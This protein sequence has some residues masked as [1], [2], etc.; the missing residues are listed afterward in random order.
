MK[1]HLLFLFL[2]FSSLTTLAQNL[3]FKFGGGLASHYGDFRPVGAFR[4]GVGYEIEFDQHFTF[5]PG[6]TVYGKGWKE[7]DVE[8][9]AYDDDGNQLYDEDTGLPLTGLMNRSGTQNYIQLPLIF[10]YYLRTGESRYIVFS[11]GPYA[12]VGVSGHVTTKGDTKRPGAERY[13]YEKKTFSEGGIK[14]F[15]AGI[16]AMV[17]YQFPIGLTVGAEADF[18]LIKVNSRGD[19]NISGILTI[20]Y[21]LSR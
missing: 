4:I 6:L 9:F 1:R 17:G 15:D 13:F 18:G 3:Q 12:A 8:V 11:A 5:T 10:S 7:R 20:G 16:Q 21:K 2:L 14:R 19:R